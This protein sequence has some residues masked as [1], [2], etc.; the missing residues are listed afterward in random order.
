MS[1]LHMAQLSVAKKVS[2]KNDMLNGG[3]LTSKP[4]TDV[5]EIIDKQPVK[6]ENVMLLPAE[7][8]SMSQH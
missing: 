1:R 4:V 2:E 8:F 6:D 7:L 3:T 5:P